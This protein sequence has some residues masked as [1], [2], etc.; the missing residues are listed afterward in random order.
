MTQRVT[1]GNWRGHRWTY[2]CLVAGL[3]AVGSAAGASGPCTRG[4][5]EQDSV[6][7]VSSR[8]A[9]SCRGEVRLRY[10]QLLPR[11][12]S[13][14]ASWHLG[15]EEQ[16]REDALQ[17][18]RTLI[19]VHGNRVSQGEAR[20][21]V[22]A[23]YRALR[24]QFRDDSP[25]QLVVWSWPTSRLRGGPLKDVR[26]K[27]QRARPTAY[28]LAW[29]VDR[30]DPDVPLGMMGFSLGSRVI[31]GALHLLGGGRLGS[32]ALAE[33]TH[34]ERLPVRA[35]LMA[36]ALDSDWLLPC[37]YHGRAM[38]QVDRVLLLNNA[39]DPAMRWYHLIDRCG[40]PQALGLH[41]LDCPSRLGADRAKVC[42]RNVCRD[43]GRQHDFFS[44]ICCASLMRQ[45]WHYL[46]FDDRRPLSV[47]QR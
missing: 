11:A 3:W 44:Y 9:G 43:V 21:R 34:P 17:R 37:R 18:N 40:R 7:V 41:G 6:W 13:T 46:A 14:T 19:Y 47:A 15:D 20:R 12:E 36:S 23:V 32:F 31:T 4:L 35:V 5:R 16:F 33:R 27:A 8:H 39:C 42:Q 29:F 30:I 2:A 38:S 45:V 1:G 22:M 24:R 25:L 10:W 26:V 28:Q